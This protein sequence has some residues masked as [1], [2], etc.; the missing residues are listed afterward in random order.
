MA[1]KGLFEPDPD[2]ELIDGKPENE[3]ASDKAVSD[4]TLKRYREF[5]FDR[6][7]V[8]SA[9]I[10]EMRRGDGE[11]A[12]YWSRIMLE[13]GD[14]G[15][16]NAESGYMIRRL[17]ILATE[18]L[19]PT[20]GRWAVPYAAALSKCAHETHAINWATW[21]MAKAK[22][23]WETDEGLELR[24]TVIEVKGEVLSWLKGKTFDWGTGEWRPI[25][26]GELAKKRP[27]PSYAVDIHTYRG[28][29]AKNRG[30]A[31]DERMSGNGAGVA[32]RIIQ[33]E[34][35]G[36]DSKKWKG[37]LVCNWGAGDDADW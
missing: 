23:W 15:Q 9:W 35:N 3:R 27:I 10:K 37:T 24:R 19:C 33:G 12:L 32:E 18:D 7:E 13:A 6:Y 2:A 16:G 8:V 11:A 5:N 25:K 29:G 17:Q 30:E 21:V 28:K 36:L 20:E 14:L 26:D 34:K 1:T 31:V 4:R 22:K